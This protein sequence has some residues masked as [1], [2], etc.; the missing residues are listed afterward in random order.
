MNTFQDLTKISRLEFNYTVDVPLNL[1]K[2]KVGRKLEFII[3]FTREGSYPGFG[4]KMYG[5]FIKNESNYGVEQ[6]QPNLWTG[7]PYHALTILKEILV[8]RS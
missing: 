2:I 8:S 3:I 5:E 4:E 6:L 1:G 7:G